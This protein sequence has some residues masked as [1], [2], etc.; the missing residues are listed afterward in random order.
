M[1]RRE[2]TLARRESEGIRRW[3]PFAEMERLHR[4]MDRL[5]DRLFPWSP[6][7]RWS[8]DTEI[9]FEPAV[10]I[11]ETGDEL[12]VFATLPGVEMKDIQVE[13]TADTL[14]LRGERKP[15]LA[16]ENATVHYRSAWGGHGTFEARYDLPVEIDPNKVKATLRNGI[17]EVRLPK[18]ESARTK[19]VKVQVE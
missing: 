19:A 15:L 18:V 12:V 10:D 2:V 5:F 14:I 17:L 3:D 13:A 11:Y 1:A 7:S 16:D 4:E 6:L 9:G 8:S